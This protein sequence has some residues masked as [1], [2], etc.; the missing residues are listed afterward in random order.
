M[1]GDCDA[2]QVALRELLEMAVTL[3]TERHKAKVL[4]TTVALWQRLGEPAQ[5][6]V[7]AGLLM[8]YTQHLDLSLFEPVCMELENELDT[9]RYRQALK[10]GKALT[11]DEAL[12]HVLGLLD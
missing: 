5:S 8:Q 1:A 6:A 9:Q 2:A 11:L 7:W 12:S 3:A 10:Q 4:S